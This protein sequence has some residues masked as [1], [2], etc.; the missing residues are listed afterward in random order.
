MKIRIWIAGVLLFVS[1]VFISGLHGYLLQAFASL[2]LLTF[3]LLTALPLSRFIFRGG[4]QS[5]IFAFPIGFILHSFNLAILTRVFEI[6]NAV[7]IPYIVLCFGLAFI[8][9]KYKNSAEQSWVGPD[10]LWLFIWLIATVLI[11]APAFMHVGK[12]TESGFAYR[13]YF[14]GDFFRNLA[15][16][17][18]LSHGTI[19]PANPYV[20][21]FELHYYWFFH[22][23]VAFW[24]TI[25]PGYGPDFMLVQFSLVASVFLSLPF[26]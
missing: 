3:F 5:V 26:M 15:V 21:G 18:S 6:S 11:L 13:A 23:F 17:G 14:N 24:K 8:L 22:L 1:I 16:I 7:L 19:P 10:I 4:P 9:R 2:L 12:L 20:S 25:F